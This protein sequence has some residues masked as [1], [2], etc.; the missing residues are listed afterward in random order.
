[1]Y[2]NLKIILFSVLSLICLISLTGCG[3]NWDAY[4]VKVVEPDNPITIDITDNGRVVYQGDAIDIDIYTI[5]NPKINL[6]GERYACVKLVQYDHFFK[7]YTKDYV[8]TF[9]NSLYGYKFSESNE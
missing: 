2:K 5:Q 6:S 3:S 1:M 9:S 8:H 7:V 4:K